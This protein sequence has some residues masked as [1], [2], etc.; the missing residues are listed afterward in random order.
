[1][2]CHGS[3]EF[4]KALRLN[5]R[6]AWAEF[7]GLTGLRPRQPL[8]QES[9]ATH[10]RKTSPSPRLNPLQMFLFIGSQC[11]T[12]NLVKLLLDRARSD[13]RFLGRD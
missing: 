4:S 10:G 9:T 13:H 2:N 6:D 3:M 5:I 7:F 1:M 11:S 8:T 12:W